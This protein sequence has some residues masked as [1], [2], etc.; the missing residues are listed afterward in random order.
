VEV[1]IRVGAALDASVQNL[2]RPVVESAKQ[3]RKQIEAELNKANIAKGVARG[4]RDV[5]RELDGVVRAARGAGRASREAGERSARGVSAIAKAAMEAGATV[6]KRLVAALNRAGGAPQEGARR[7]TRE[8]TRAIDTVDRYA[9][10]VGRG[11]VQNIGR[12]TRAAADLAKDVA[13]GAGV[14]FNIGGSIQRAVSLQKTSV[15]I[16]NSA[17]AAQGRSATA[18]EAAAVQ[19]TVMATGDAARLDY[20]NVAA[21]L[22]DFLSKTGDLK[23]GQAVLEDLANTARATASDFKEMA[24]M[25]GEISMSLPESEDKA[26]RVAAIARLIAKQGAMGNVEVRDLAQYGGR[27]SAGA[28]MYQGTIDENIG[29]LGALAQIA[30]KG[31]ATSAAEATNSAQSFSRDLTKK[32]ALK[33]FKG[34]GLDIFADEGKT[35]LRDPKEII[36][37]YLKKSGGNLAELAKY[38]QNDVSKRVIKGVSATYGEAEAKKKGSGLEAV[39]K[40]FAEYSKT[41]TKEDVDKAAALSKNTL[42]ARAQA[43]QN[44]LDTI[45]QKMAGDL[46]P[47]LEKL[48]PHI[49]KA[50]E[51]FAQLLQ[52]TVENPGEAILAVIVASIGKAAIGAGVQAAIEAAIRGAAG[53]G[54]TGGLPG[55]IG[56]GGSVLGAGAGQAF[57]VTAAGGL[58]AAGAGVIGGGLAV[59]LGA[60]L[61]EGHQMWERAR[62]ERAGTA[63]TAAAILDSPR[64][65]INDAL[66]MHGVDMPANAGLYQGD[67]RMFASTSDEAD[68]LEDMARKGQGGTKGGSFAISDELSMRLLARTGQAQ[69][70]PEATASVGMSNMSMEPGATPGWV[71]DLQMGIEKIVDKTREAPAPPEMKSMLQVMQEQN[72]LLSTIA[73]NT[74]AGQAPTGSG[75]RIGMSGDPL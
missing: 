61:Y 11:T 27:L 53:G 38:F 58:T 42:E 24:S 13:R 45:G 68:K 29:R 2:F 3:A 12:A 72:A 67:L 33:R 44:Q 39:D 70:S 22:Q 9:V 34:L 35:K 55:V 25:A 15:D 26:A 43:F 63:K 41:L 62:E 6:D 64:Q 60:S 7:F 10:R 16:A 18:E 47:A 65:K 48:T 52:W 66:R 75:P 49:L 14:D 21:G 28:F 19:K 20:G 74:S 32:A 57:G 4:A 17:A 71:T 51:S 46:L 36:K 23:T 8:Y 40:M 37:D 31:G 56:A 5:Q 73:S 59:G 30:R 1:R 54:V 50:A 69:S